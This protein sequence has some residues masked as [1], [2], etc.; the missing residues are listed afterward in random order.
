MSHAKGY[1]IKDSGTTFKPCQICGT[2]MKVYLSRAPYKKFC[3]RK[4]KGEWQHKIWRGKNH[5]SYRRIKRICKIC[6]KEFWIQRKRLKVKGG[7]SFCSKKC[8]AEARRRTMLKENP[9]H[10]VR[11]RKNWWTLM[12]SKEIREKQIR[13]TLKALLKRPTSLEKMFIGVIDRY[14]LPYKY[15]GDGSFLIGFKNPDFI[16]VNG[17]KTCIEVRGDYW[18]SD[19]WAKERV[20]HFAKWGWRCIIFKGSDVQNLSVEELQKSGIEV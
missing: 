20:R 18:Y 14:K 4:C 16:D 15:V 7:G 3:T 11:V 5:P 13:N 1:I 6:G 19:K 8:F 2:L 17:G 10:N 9:M 12:H